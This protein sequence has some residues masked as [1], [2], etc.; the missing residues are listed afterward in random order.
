MRIFVAG[1]TGVIGRRVTRLLVDAGHRV[2]G[3]VRSEEK[4]F[5][6]AAVG[7]EPARIDLFDAD[8]VHTTVSGHDVV[9]NLAT[10]IPP[11]SEAW[12]KSA[13][14]TNHRI[15]REGSSI[16]TRAAMAAGARRFVQESITLV[17]A[18][19]GESW[20]DES[21]PV[22]PTWITTSALDAEESA[23]R[24]GGDDPMAAGEGRTAVV[25]RFALFY[26]PDSHHSLAAIEA[27]RHGWAMTMGPKDAY[28]PA[29]QI[30]DAAAAAVAAL[31][32]PGGV[33]N[34]ADLEPLTR[35]AHF[36]AL[37]R[38]VGR[39]RLHHPPA[40]LGWLMGPKNRMLMRS[41]RVGSRRFRE[42]TGW[43]PRYE[44]AREGWPAV[45]RAVDEDS[46][47]AG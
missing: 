3:L 21:A 25:L 30:D 24:F 31:E 2:T 1:A 15:R 23:R 34:V 12:K 18:D 20:L 8:A 32:A 4:A 28:L 42:A 22:E 9:Y 43:Q 36:A 26:G 19:A 45:V 33:Y 44:S 5:E 39:D 7:A 37:G 14:E 47:P 35:E 40:F 17:Y 10:A 29:I 38:A 41:H 16:L 27:A 13:W 11:A 46:R 6:L